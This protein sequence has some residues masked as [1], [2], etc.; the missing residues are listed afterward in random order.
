MV[1]IGE[2]RL[3][4]MKKSNLPSG[5]VAEDKHSTRVEVK[6]LHAERNVDKRVSD[7]YTY[8]HSTSRSHQ[9]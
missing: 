4:A 8:R 2:Y 9:R 6:T 5:Q 1:N 3:M 7:F